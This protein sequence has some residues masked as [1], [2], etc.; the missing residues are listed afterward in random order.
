MTYKVTH[1]TKEY[2]WL[3][4]ITNY[5]FNINDSNGYSW[6]GNTPQEFYVIYSKKPNE[7]GKNDLGFFKSGD[8]VKFINW[9]D[10]Q[11]PG[12]P[13]SFSN[14][15]SI[16]SSF[17]STVGLLE[18]IQSNSDIKVDSID[19]ILW[20]AYGNSVFGYKPYRTTRA[21]SAKTIRKVERLNKKN[22]GGIHNDLQP[23][24]KF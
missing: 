3:D 17:I 1:I 22:N 8:K 23:K 16:T 6:Q 10:L 4:K 7:D 21:D 2:N 18:G 13:A 12:L 19:I 24:P 20:T 5:L 11:K 14:N 15:P 9:D